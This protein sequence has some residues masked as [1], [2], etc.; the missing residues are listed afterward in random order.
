ME[1]LQLF[2]QNPFPY[3][4]M[5]PRHAR[6]FGFPEAAFIGC[7]WNNAFFASAEDAMDENNF[8][9]LTKDT[10]ERRTSLTKKQQ[11][12]VCTILSR[13]GVIDI[14]EETRDAWVLRLNIEEMDEITDKGL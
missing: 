2:P 5:D 4:G 10:V 13:L 7:L 11:K 8:F 14:A 6:V 3:G 9:C 1:A 12:A